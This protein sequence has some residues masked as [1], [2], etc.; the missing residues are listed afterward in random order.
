MYFDTNVKHLRL[1][2][3]LTQEQLAKKLDKSKRAIQ[4]YERGINKP[5]VDHLIEIAAFFNVS[6][7]DIL[8]KDLTK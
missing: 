5:S 4:D 3:E 7:D 6:I 2:L 1:Q 8:L